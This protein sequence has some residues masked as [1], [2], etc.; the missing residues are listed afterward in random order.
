M[1]VWRVRLQAGLQVAKPTLLDLGAV[2]T[3]KVE[4]KVERRTA[5]TLRE[6]ESAAA[7]IQTMKAMIEMKPNRV[8][9]GMLK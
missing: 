4:V 8:G 3:M 2:Q 7:E 6:V 9:G 5:A 1:P